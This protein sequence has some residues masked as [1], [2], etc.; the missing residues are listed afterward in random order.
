METEVILF[1]LELLKARYE[2]YFQARL[3][4]FYGG[5]PLSSAEGQ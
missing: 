2:A 1:S 3:L 4:A 5:E